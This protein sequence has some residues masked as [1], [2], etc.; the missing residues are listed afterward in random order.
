MT[1]TIKWGDPIEPGT[2][3]K[4]GVYPVQQFV[5]WGYGVNAQKTFVTTQA[6]E[7]KS[8][9]STYTED[10]RFYRTWVAADHLITVCTC[11]PK[12]VCGIHG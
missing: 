4:F 7:V 6:S 9:I 8:G 10:N 1:K 11:Q 2:E 3:V 5:A 12:P